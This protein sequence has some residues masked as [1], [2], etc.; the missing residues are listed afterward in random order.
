MPYVHLEYKVLT[1]SQTIIVENLVSI[2]SSSD[3]AT[4]EGTT[5]F[6]TL[7]YRISVVITYK[8]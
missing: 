2:S 6:I 3:C 8:S 5:I 1:M 7:T 4:I